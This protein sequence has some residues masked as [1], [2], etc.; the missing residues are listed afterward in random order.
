ML[1]KYY[2]IHR[3]DQTHIH[4]ATS[5]NLATSTN[6]FNLPHVEEIPNTKQN[7]SYSKKIYSLLLIFI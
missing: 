3:I 4:V 7:Q 2:V 1:E 6:D 5:T